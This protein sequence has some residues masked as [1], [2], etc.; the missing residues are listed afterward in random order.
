[1]RSEYNLTE[2]KALYWGNAKKL[3]QSVHEYE[4]PKRDL[5]S[6][7]TSERHMGLN[8]FGCY[9]VA[10]A[11]AAAAAG[12]KKERQEYRSSLAQRKLQRTLV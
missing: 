4:N 7:R 10:V 1:M 6:L 9:T 3:Y 11:V 8:L 12:K 5:L 2:G